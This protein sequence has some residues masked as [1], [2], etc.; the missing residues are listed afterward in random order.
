V[1]EGGEEIL[2]QRDRPDSENGRGRETITPSGHRWF[3][4]EIKHGRVENLA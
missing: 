3:A 1:N 4:R 2:E